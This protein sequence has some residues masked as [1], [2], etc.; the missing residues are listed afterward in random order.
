VRR[1]RLRVF[2]RAVVV[3]IGGDAG[4][5]ERMTADFGVEVGV[6]GAAADHAPGVDAVHRQSRQLAGAAARGA[7]QG[8]PLR[9]PDPGRVQIGVEVGFEIVVVAGHFMDLAALLV[10]PH[11]PAFALPEI[12]LDAHRDR[13]ADAR[14]PVEKRVAALPRA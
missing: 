14:G 9:L 11:P 10:Q 3:E 5:P 13:G 7:E 6:P 12:I 4:R 8:S 1:H 2:E